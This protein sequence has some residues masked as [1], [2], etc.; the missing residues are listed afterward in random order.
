M[1]KNKMSYVV[2]IICCLMLSISA[3]SFGQ[4]MTINAYDAGSPALASGDT[5]EA[6]WVV[7]QYNTAHNSI[8]QTWQGYSQLS[9]ATDL[10]AWYPL[11]GNPWSHLTTFTIYNPSLPLITTQDFEVLLGVK[12]HKNGGTIVAGDQRYSG[13]MN[14][15]QLTGSFSVNLY[16]Q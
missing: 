7:F 14:T 5:Y 10:W 9:P 13:W 15:S 16:I 11:Y 1:R 8:I 3:M 12:R 2:T 4:S 6:S